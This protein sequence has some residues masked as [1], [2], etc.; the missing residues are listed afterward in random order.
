MTVIGM[1]LKTRRAIFKGICWLGNEQEKFKFV[2]FQFVSNTLLAV[3]ETA[4]LAG[5]TVLLHD[6][7]TAGV[8]TD[9][10]KWGRQKNIY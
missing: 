6:A 4:C 9:E 3:P 7:I 5:L 2:L 10:N 1:K 8:R